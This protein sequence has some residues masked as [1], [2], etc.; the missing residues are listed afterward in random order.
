VKVLPISLDI[1]D[2]G[3]GSNHHHQHTVSQQVLTCQL[4]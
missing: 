4:S 3:T 1:T 2:T